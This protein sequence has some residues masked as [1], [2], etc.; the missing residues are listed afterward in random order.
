MTPSD[1]AARA[2]AC[3][4]PI[5]VKISTAARSRSSASTNRSACSASLPARSSRR[6][7]S[8][9]LLGDRGGVV[10]GA[11]PVLGGAE[12]RRALARALEPG[13]RRQPAC[14]R[15]RS[16]RVGLERVAM[17]RGDDLGDLVGIDPRV[18]L[19]VRGRCAMQASALPLAPA[20]R[21]PPAGRAP[22]GSRTAPAPGE[23]GSASIVSSSL[24]TRRSSTGATVSSSASPRPARPRAP[25]V[26]PS[27]AAC[28]ISSR[29][30]GSSPSSRAAISA[31]SVSGMSRSSSE[32][33]TRKRVC[34]RA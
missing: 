24:R 16:V 8:S 12:R 22:G 1:D 6:A 7:R 33:A 30:S 14:G 27:T 31:W 28:W 20:S 9:R 4:S 13:A 29:S 18:V 10:E 11:L 25:K 17:V 21:R 26:L 19:E 34:R 3:V 5:A 23:R 32:P 15:V 2:A